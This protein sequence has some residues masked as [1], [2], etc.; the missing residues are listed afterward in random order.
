MLN[1]VMLSVIMLNV[2]CA[3]Y[4]CAECRGVL[5]MAW[6]S[7][8]LG[9]CSSQRLSRKRLDPQLWLLFWSGGMPVLL[10]C[11]QGM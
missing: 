10:A 7:Q 9:Q 6:T 3:E 1:V 8:Q 2:I 4:R 11:P 5:H